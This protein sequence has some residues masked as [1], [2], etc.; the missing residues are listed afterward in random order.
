MKKYS[1]LKTRAT[2]LWTRYI[3]KGFGKPE[4]QNRVTNSS[5]VLWRQL[6][7]EKQNKF[8]RVIIS[9]PRPQGILPSAAL[10]HIISLFCV[11][12]TVIWVS[13][14]CFSPFA[15]GEDSPGTK[16]F[17]ALSNWLT[18]KAWLCSC[19]IFSTSYQ[20]RVFYLYWKSFLV[21]KLCKKCL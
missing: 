15:S 5:Y 11:A 7:M 14:Y 6:E 17:N 19:Q 1:N 3:N 10:Y 8:F 13:C 4:L 2:F 9:Q 20:M 21:H 16:G 12:A 18:L